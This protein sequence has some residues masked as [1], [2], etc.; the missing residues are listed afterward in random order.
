MRR[1]S[2][3]DIS[4]WT[5]GTA[6][7]DVRRSIEADL[8]QPDSLVRE[9]LEWL[10]G[11]SVRVSP[12][13][14]QQDFSDL[15]P[16]IRASLENFS[17]DYEANAVESTPD[18]AAFPQ[19]E[20]ECAPRAH[21]PSPLSTNGDSDV[22]DPSIFATFGQVGT[23]GA[24]PAKPLG[25][26]GTK[27]PQLRTDGRRVLVNALELA[28]VPGRI[29]IK[30][31]RVIA[32]RLPRFIDSGTVDSP[33]SS[34]AP[35]KPMRQP[36]SWEWP[37]DPPGWRPEKGRFT[38]VELLITI[39]I[40]GTLMAV[41]LP[42]VLTAREAAR[43]AQCVNNLKQ[44]VLAAHNYESANGSFPMGNRGYTFSSAGTFPPC[45]KYLGHS[46]F[47]FMLP[48]IENGAHYDGYNFV[49]PGFSAFNATAVSCPIAAF[50]CPSDTAA[51]PSWPGYITPAQASYGTSRGLSETIILN[52]ATPGKSPP[53]PAGDYYERCNQGLGDGLF[54][55]E[56]SVRISDVTD[57][58]SNT[59]AFGEMSRFTNEPSGSSFYFS[60]I[61]GFWRGPPWNSKTPHWRNDQRITGGAYQVPRPNSPPDTE[62]SVYSRCFARAVGPRDW[63][64]NPQCWNLGQF[65]FRSQ[66]PGG[67]N[68]AFADGSVKFIKSSINSQT[69]RAL[70]T[71]AG[72][73]VVASDQY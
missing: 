24:Q 7:E 17:F 47:A 67:T 62:G 57:G 30:F 61:T 33:S 35:A 43:R 45:S 65:G 19:V 14:V 6:K 59:F 55:T 60:V 44:I 58:T 37:L 54:G 13:L 9:Y 73:E 38:L 25:F 40:I 72:R 39:G 23:A 29:A 66:H 53:D 68:F 8:L 15:S 18:Y 46:A 48:Y 49:L 32:Q 10:G 27:R 69:Y 16:A 56:G 52:W 4:D 42:A 1:I 34:A 51:V 5:L 36:S 22:V 21:A 28:A 71:R 41:V 3:Q 12:R 50:I 63:I 26:A 31:A 20:A 2:I 64:D 11:A 70:G